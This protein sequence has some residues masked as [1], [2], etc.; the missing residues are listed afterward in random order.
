[1]QARGET[2]EIPVIDLALFR[3]GREVDRRI[4]TK[5]LADASKELGFFYIKNHG[6]GQ[7]QIDGMFDLAQEFFSLPE[8]AKMEVAL[9]KSRN[10]RGYLPGNTKGNAGDIKPNLQEAFQIYAELSPGDPDLISGN[11]MLGPNPWPSAMPKLKPRMLGYFDQLSRLSETLLRMFAIG[12]NLPEETFSARF[13]KPMN[14][15]RLLHYPPQGAISLEEAIGTRAHTDSSAMT[16]L[17]L[18]EVAGLQVYTK[19]EEWIPV[20]RIEGT[21]VVNTGEIMK[22][23]TGGIFRSARHRVINRTGQERYSVPFFATPSFDEILKPLMT[24]PDPNEAA[25]D[26]HPLLKS[27]SEMMCGDFLQ[28]QFGRIYPTG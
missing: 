27:G 23:W 3:S 4:V 13:K 5:A 9:M 1:M 8:Q 28:Q 26:Y 10:F 11:P 17:A 24:N 22:L 25:P 19:T 6:I 15:L 18:D 20:R 2:P 21:F 14:W 7:D 16:I 12:L